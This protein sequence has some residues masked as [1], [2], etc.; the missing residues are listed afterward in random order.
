MPRPPRIHNT[1]LKKTFVCAQCNGNFRSKAGRTRHINAK[2]SGLHNMSPASDDEAD[3]SSDMSS[4]LNPGTPGHIF[5]LPTC[6]RDTLNFGAQ[7]ATASGSEIDFNFNNDNIDD[8]PLLSPSRDRDMAS[9]SVEYH[10]YLNGKM[11]S[12]L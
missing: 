7:A 8:T 9:T 5:D 12:N 6:N 2:H 3:L 4:Y 10:P 11:N 1:P